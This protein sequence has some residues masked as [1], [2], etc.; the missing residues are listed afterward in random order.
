M[1]E[2]QTKFSTDNWVVATWDEYIQAI[3][4]TL[5]AV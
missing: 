2:L 4:E 5:R 1:I 3:E